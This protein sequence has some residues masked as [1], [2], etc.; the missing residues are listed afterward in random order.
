MKLLLQSNPKDNISFYPYGNFSDRYS[1]SHGARDNAI[2]MFSS[3][4]LPVKT[5]I[6]EHFAVF[7][8]LHSA[9]PSFST[10][11]VTAQS[12]PGHAVLAR[13]A[14]LRN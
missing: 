6:S 11:N 3:K 4:Q 7:N 10:P 13:L 14:L 9:V 2:Q 8:N 12:D 1:H 5:A